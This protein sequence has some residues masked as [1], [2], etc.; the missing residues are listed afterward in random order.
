MTPKA[1][2]NKDFPLSFIKPYTRTCIH[3]LKAKAKRWT[4]NNNNNNNNI[5]NTNKKNIYKKIK[6]NN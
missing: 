6:K 1:A 4:N 3:N 5:D 2:F